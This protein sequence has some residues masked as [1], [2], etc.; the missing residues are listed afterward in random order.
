MDR[1]IIGEV[2]GGI[3]MNSKGIH[4]HNNYEYLLDKNSEFECRRLLR[5]IKSAIL[6]IEKA[7]NMFN[8]VDDADLIEIAIYAEDMAK[9]RY[10]Y[11]LAIAKRIGM[12]VTN[13]YVIKNNLISFTE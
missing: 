10:A 2:L 3:V 12:N 6:E 11:L 9:K 5:D 1:N 7:R 8:N 4:Q 13:S